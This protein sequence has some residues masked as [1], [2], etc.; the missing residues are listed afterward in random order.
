MAEGTACLMKVRARD[1]LTATPVAVKA[2]EVYRIS[3]AN[4]QVWF[5]WKNE[6]KASAGLG[7]TP[8]M[9]LFSWSKRHPDA[10][11]FALM[12]VVLPDDDTSEAVPAGDL[13]RSTIYR[14][15]ASGRLALYPNDASLHLFG[16]P[17]FYLNN[18]GAIWALI[19]RCGTARIAPGAE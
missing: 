5:D 2:G 16:Q 13:T 8:F 10:R 6:S 18:H 12:V 17:V 9:N 11:W 1:W 3:A 15:S 14:A 4:D 19:E 7:G